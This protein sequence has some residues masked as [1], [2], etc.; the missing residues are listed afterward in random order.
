MLQ[1]RNKLKKDLKYY[2]SN[3]WELVYIDEAIDK[4]SI[5]IFFRSPGKFHTRFPDRVYYVDKCMY[6]PYYLNKLKINLFNET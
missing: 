6:I 5:V 3:D 1:A 4:K 2:W